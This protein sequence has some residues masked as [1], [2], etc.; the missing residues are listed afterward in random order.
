MCYIRSGFW[1]R[2]QFTRV[3]RA[4]D[5]WGKLCPRPSVA[6]LLVLIT[7]PVTIAHP[8]R[9]IVPFLY[10][11]CLGELITENSIGLIIVSSQ[12]VL[13]LLWWA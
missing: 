4:L 9:V 2:G 8:C 5:T 13:W 1:S 7:F 10:Y 12:R 6:L 11:V 3:E